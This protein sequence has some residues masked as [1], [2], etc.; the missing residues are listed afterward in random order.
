MMIYSFQLL[1][2]TLLIFFNQYLVQGT[3]YSC[4]ITAPCGCSENNAVINTRIVGGETAVSHSW[5]WSV[6]L[7]I[8]NNKHFC[9]GT[10]L[11]PHYILTAA[12]CVDDSQIAKR[13]ITVAIGTDNL[14]DN[15]G[16]RLIVSK[17]HIHSRWNRNTKENDIAILEL[18]QPISFDDKS[19]AKLCLPSLTGYTD[20]EFPWTNSKLIAIGWGTTSSGGTISNTLRQVTIEAAGNREPKCS[21]S[22]RNTRLQFCAAVNGGGKGN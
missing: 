6:S 5:G 22:I 17:I 13:Q 20:T 15:N 1:L 21:N 11:S 14:Y 2:I 10:V 18:K 19:V 3:I 9:G 8:P 4:N 16:Q 7:R 12:H